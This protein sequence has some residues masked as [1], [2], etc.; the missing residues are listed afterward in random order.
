MH[1]HTLV[2]PNVWALAPRIAPVEKTAYSV[3]KRLRP[4]EKNAIVQ[5]CERQSGIINGAVAED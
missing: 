3:E 4:V 2:S 1:F 5:G